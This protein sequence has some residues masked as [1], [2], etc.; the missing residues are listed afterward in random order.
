MFSQYTGDVKYSLILQKLLANICEMLYNSNT[1]TIPDSVEEMGDRL[2]SGCKNLTEA[3][4]PKGVEEIIS[5]TFEGCIN[6]EQVTLPERIK[7]I[8]S[9]AFTGCTN[10]KQ[11]TLP[12]GVQ[13]IEG[14]AFQDCASLTSITLPAS[15]PLKTVDTSYGWRI[16]VDC[17]SRAAFEGCTALTEFL[18]APGSEYYSS[19]DGFLCNAQGDT[20]LCVPPGLESDSLT[21]PPCI[22]T[23]GSDAFGNCKTMEKLSIPETVTVIEKNAFSNMSSLRELTISDSVEWIHME[24]LADMDSLTCLNLGKKT[25]FGSTS[26]LVGTDEILTDP[27]TP[28]FSSNPSLTRITV[29]EE[30]P[31]YTV[32][33]DAMLYNHDG[34]VLIACSPGIIPPVLYIPEGTQEIAY[35][36][37]YGMDELEEI[38]LPAGFR[39]FGSYCFWC[40]NDLQK[41]TFQDDADL[42]TVLISWDCFSGT[43]LL[44]NCTNEDGIAI[45]ENGMMLACPEGLEE[46]VIPASVRAIAESGSLT[47]LRFGKTTIF[48]GNARFN[49]TNSI[50][51]TEHLVIKGDAYF[52]EHSLNNIRSLQSVSIGGNCT[53]ETMFYD[54]EWGDNDGI[55]EWTV[56]GTLTHEGGLPGDITNL[57]YSRPPHHYLLGDN[58]EGEVS[59]AQTSVRTLEPGVC[60][61]YYETVEE[62]FPTYT[63]RERDV[64]YLQELR[65][66]FGNCSS[67]VIPGGGITPVYLCPE[68]PAAPIV[69]IEHEGCHFGTSAMD[70]DGTLYILWGKYIS[71]AEGGDTLILCKYDTQGNLLGEC[72]IPNSFTLSSEPFRGGNPFMVITNGMAV[73]QYPTWWYDT[74]IQ[75]SGVCAVD[76]A[77]MTEVRNTYY[78]SDKVNDPDNPQNHRHS[79]SMALCMIPTAFGAFAAEKNDFI[80]MDA[81]IAGE[82]SFMVDK[83]RSNFSSYDILFADPDVGLYGLT[84]GSTTY[85]MAGVSSLS[86]TGRSNAFLRIVDQALTASAVDLAGEDVSYTYEDGPTFVTHNVIWLTDVDEEEK[87][88]SVKVTTLGDG[89]YCA[90]WEQSKNGE[91]SVWYAVFDECGN[92]L[93]R[94]T[95]LENARLSNTT[96]Q[97]FAE[98]TKLKW[99]GL[100][101]GAVTWYQ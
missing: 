72:G 100:T 75:G 26:I 33:N 30:N 7:A 94:A 41:V 17:L 64:E 45:T 78:Y 98:G 32:R 34:T 47:P 22:T 59:A 21:L 87:V 15:L 36:C 84:A 9:Y 60:D 6:L 25:Q 99:A 65:D 10:L 49:A 8:R 88:G 79:Y 5:H 54:D 62:S 83:I 82:G 69:K 28:H 85:A 46:L 42:D 19:Q 20:L 27:S 14:Y 29:P 39:R 44:K 43:A 97:P 16:E 63:I 56:G 35:E 74:N 93:R 40:A 80:Y 4:L 58:P 70:T 50:Q 57:S 1:V 77:T 23:I 2:F 52:A 31:Y 37:F 53:C 96:V 11:V 68:D 90:L 91:G 38:V 12:E 101:N 55:A 95:R 81:H 18:V 71:V 76:T 86:P 3:I 61:P 92:L 73:F 13:T 51:Y 24:A 66:G 89:S 67:L 48:E